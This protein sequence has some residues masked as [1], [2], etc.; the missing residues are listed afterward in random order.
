LKYS[1]IVFKELVFS[2]NGK[3]AVEGAVE[4]KNNTSLRMM[5][6]KMLLNVQEASKKK[7]DEVA[8]RL[9]KYRYKHTCSAV[10][11]AK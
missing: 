10:P 9:D 11:L 6:L 4:G 1:D 8:Y 2:E 7:H 3:G 5:V